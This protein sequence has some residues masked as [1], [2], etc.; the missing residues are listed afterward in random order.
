MKRLWIE[1][2]NT[3][4]ITFGGLEIDTVERQGAL[5][6]CR[7]KG[8]DVELILLEFEDPG[9]AERFEFDLE[10]GA[11]IYI[12]EDYTLE[13]AP[14]Q[15]QEEYQLAELSDDKERLEAVLTELWEEYGVNPDRDPS[16][17]ETSGIQR[18]VATTD[19][20]AQV[21]GFQ[22]DNV[23]VLDW[24]QRHGYAGPRVIQ[25]F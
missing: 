17:R 12:E 23:K 10:S 20:I 4:W 11:I 16:E 19:D 9:L 21:V 5:V 7:C 15:L 1:E 25:F 6:R 8:D 14:R 13:A 22:R 24:L 3:P 2:F 18:M